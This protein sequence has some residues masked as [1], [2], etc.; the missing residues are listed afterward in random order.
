[1]FPIL[2]LPGVERSHWLYRHVLRTFDRAESRL[3]N[4]C[5][6]RGWIICWYF[7]RFIEN[8]FDDHDNNEDDGE[9]QKAAVEKAARITAS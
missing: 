9:S 7:N 4:R 6:N 3:L 2:I 8:G 1:M 5:R